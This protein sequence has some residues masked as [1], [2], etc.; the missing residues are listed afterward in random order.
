MEIEKE[1]KDDVRNKRGI[2]VCKDG[3]YIVSGG[4]PLYELVVDNDAEDYPCDYHVSKKYPSQENYSLCRCGQ[5]NDKPFCDG[6]H[7]TVHFNG[8]ETASRAPYL[9][10]AEELD[11]PALIL[12]DVRELCS[13][14]GMCLRAGGIRELVLRSNDPDAKRAALKEVANC[15]SGRLVAFDKETGKPIEPEFEPS[16]AVV[17]EPRRGY[18]GP[19]WVRGGIPIEAADG[20][21][22]EIRNRV[23]LCRCGI[24]SAK[25]FCDGSHR[26]MND[27]FA[28]NPVGGRPDTQHRR[29][30][31][32]AQ[33]E[34]DG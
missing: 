33:T 19:A 7:E 28:Q 18:S 20:S 30:E 11:G 13:H 14:V 22:Y 24:S 29:P 3:P 9:A 2:Q 34:D 5:S 10:R 4:I 12:A 25:P 15:N 21:T 32:A 31:D 16:I 17:K 8:T 26:V 27:G 23:A 6:T 1:A